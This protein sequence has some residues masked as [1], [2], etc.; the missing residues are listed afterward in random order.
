[1]KVIKYLLLA[2]V[3][4][5]S[6]HSYAGPGKRIADIVAATIE[7][8]E[9]EDLTIASVMIDQLSKSSD[10]RS[11]TRKL[12]KGNDYSA[13]ATG[14]SS[15]SD[16]DMTVYRKSSSGDWVQ[17]GKDIDSSNTCIVDFKCEITGDY[18]FEVKAYS[19]SS[20]STNGYFGFILAFE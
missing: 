8:L 1:M 13:V 6:L 11:Y 14:S 20:G 7:Y 4:F 2:L 12:Y 17:V 19:F 18:K 10:T 9:D 3:S 16:I 15:F 5:V